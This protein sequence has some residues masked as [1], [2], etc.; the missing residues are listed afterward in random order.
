MAIDPIFFDIIESEL[1]TY[2]GLGLGT[3]PIPPSPASVE[4]FPRPIG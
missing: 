2:T 3:P 4:S 1:A